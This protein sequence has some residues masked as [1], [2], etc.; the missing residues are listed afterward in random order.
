MIED[1]FDEPE[2]KSIDQQ[3]SEAYEKYLEHF[4]PEG[5]ENPM[6]FEEFIDYWW[7]Y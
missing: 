1:R 7:R 5:Y 6:S 4:E 3:A 2:L